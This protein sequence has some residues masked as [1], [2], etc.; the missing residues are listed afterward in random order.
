MKYDETT[1]QLKRIYD[2]PTPTDGFRVLVDR[3]WPRGVSKEDA[4]LDLWLGDIAPSPSLRKWFN[5][6][7]ARWDEFLD[8]YFAEL[9]DNPQAV[10]ELFQKATTSPI[11]L[12][13]AAKDERHNHAAALKLYLEGES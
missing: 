6:D 12:L 3:L 11:T 13:Y 2:D 4:Q 5:H 10:T 1:L 8:R 7:P 9:D